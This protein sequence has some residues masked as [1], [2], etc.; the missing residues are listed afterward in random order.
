MRAGLTVGVFILREIE[1]LHTLEISFIGADVARAA[2]RWIVSRYAHRQG[3]GNSPRYLAFEGED[4]V[5]PAVDALRPFAEA[6]ATA[7]EVDGD[8]HDIADALDG[9]FEQIGDTDLAGE[10]LRVA[11]NAGGRLRRSRR[12]HLEPVVARQRRS[13]L[14]R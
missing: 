4:V 8:P 7:D 14:L 1:Q 12:E 9:A 2:R 3:F 13:Y 11:G 10:R 6:R 5:Q